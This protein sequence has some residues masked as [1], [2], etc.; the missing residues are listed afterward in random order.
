MMNACYSF[1][2]GLCHVK[3]ECLW[4]IMFCFNILCF[5]YMFHSLFNFFLRNTKL[6]NYHCNSKIKCLLTKIL[7][8]NLFIK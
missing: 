1:T 6:R 2:L 7:N 3:N 8:Y 5:L 4:S